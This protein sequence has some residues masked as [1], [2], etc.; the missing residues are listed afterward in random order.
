MKALDLLNEVLPS[1]GR[2]SLG[3]PCSAGFLCN[4]GAAQNFRARASRRF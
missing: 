3:F 4:L 2:G 1:K